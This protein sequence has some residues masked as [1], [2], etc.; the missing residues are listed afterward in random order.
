MRIEAPFPLDG[1]RLGDSVAVNGACL[2][3]VTLEAPFFEVE[4]SPESLAR[5]TL[6]QL[7]VGE[8]VNLERALKVGDRLGGHL[9]TGHVDGVGE[10]LSREE[11]GNFIFFR[12]RAPESVARYLVEKGSVA[13][14]GVS[15]TVN[16][17]QGAVFELAIIPHTARLTTMGF[18]KP[19]DLVNLEADLLAKYVEKF[20]K[21]YQE[22]SLTEEFIRE[23]GFF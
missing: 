4:V 14:D 22:R 16:R 12:I 18:R 6:G 2:T 5:T 21:P 20:L 19:G 7:K 1:T 10:V 23:K 17:V 8:K 13:V 11:R 15:L 9:V 3:V